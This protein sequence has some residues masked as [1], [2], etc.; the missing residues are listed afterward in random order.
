[1]SEPESTYNVILSSVR[2]IEGG[3]EAA[4]EAFMHRFGLGR[5]QATKLVD[6]VPAVVKKGIP[7]EEA[8]RVA[9]AMREIGA[10]VRLQEVSPRALS[11]AEVASAFVGVTQPIVRPGSAT[12]ASGHAAGPG[13]ANEA[14]GDPHGDSGPHGELA[15][16]TD[17]AD[18][19]APTGEAAS[20]GLP[21][22][23]GSVEP[24]PPHEQGRR[25]RETSEFASLDDLAESLPDSDPASRT[26]ISMLMQGDEPRAFAPGAPPVVGEKPGPERPGEDSWSG[27]QFAGEAPEPQ[28]A[29]PPPPSPEVSWIERFSHAEPG[30]KTP[31]PAVTGASSSPPSHSAPGPKGDSPSS[32][33]PTITERRPSVLDELMAL[34]EEA[35]SEPEPEPTPPPVVQ[36][37][38]PAVVPVA[39][40][41]RGDARKTVAQPVVARRTTG[42]EAMAEPAPPQPRP[43]KGLQPKGLQA[44]PEL[45]APQASASRPVTPIEVPDATDPDSPVGDSA[46]GPVLSSGIDDA[47]AE[48]MGSQSPAG[49]TGNR[50][51]AQTGSR[52]AN[53]APT[54]ATQRVASTTT[55][56]RKV[57]KSKS[58]RAGVIVSLVLLLAIA[59]AVAWEAYRRSSPAFRFGRADTYYEWTGEKDGLTWV[60][61]C[62]RL[63]EG[64]L[65]CRYSPEWYRTEF[66]GLEISP[67][68]AASD[69]CF[70]EAVVSGRKAESVMTCAFK[71]TMVGVLKEGRLEHR[72]LRDCKEPLGSL[73][74]GGTTSC[75][76][77]T[78]SILN[79]PGMPEPRR[80]ATRSS[81]TVRYERDLSLSTSAGYLDVAELRL[82]EEGKPITIAYFSREIGDIVRV[83]ELGH[84]PVLDFGYLQNLAHSSGHRSL[85][86]NPP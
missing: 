30:P 72:S 83:A 66:G 29:A 4:I 20:G 81:V 5:P 69:Q 60:R 58:S 38:S 80:D 77:E 53:R 71:Y 43:T 15:D 36:A 56:Q 11:S 75:R 1:M 22:V 26:D 10:E 44:R 34:E 37:P 28:A 19:L 31:A 41:A 35:A 16:A 74:T 24:R 48:V 8:I 51:V 62:A 39:P 13:G 47:L 12:G 54:V 2:R 67:A 32:P 3:R 50:T 6:A 68:G 9:T 46:D 18:T 73:P 76:F 27:T 84:P 55:R 65:L 33:P 64:R 70:A 25:P 57:E 63:S 7:R 61:G 14:G 85:P 52:D 78:E 21:R 17:L 45:G 40:P 49:D 79:L 86:F 82:D 59:G 42:P 23:P